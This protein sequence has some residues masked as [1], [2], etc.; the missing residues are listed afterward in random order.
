MMLSSNGFNEIDIGIDV[1]TEKFVEAAKE[2]S[3]DI[4]ATSALLTTTMT[5]IPPIIEAL[6]KAGLKNKVKVLIGGVATSEEYATEIGA[7]GYAIDC[8]SAIDEADRLMK[9]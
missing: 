5:A 9:I 4:L 8:V 3:A 6:E 2:N 1:S 7:E